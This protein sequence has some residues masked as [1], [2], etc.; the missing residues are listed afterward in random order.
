MA[1]SAPSSRSIAGM[2]KPSQK[3]GSGCAAIATPPWRWTVVDRV[4]GALHEADGCRN[5]GGDQ[6]IARPDDFLADEHDWPADHARKPLAQA[7]VPR[8]V[9]RGDGERVE[10]LALGFEDEPQGVSAPSLHIELCV[11]KSTARTR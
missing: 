2:S 11:W 4:G 3:S 9:V 8:F 1:D 5:A 10:A 7:R 6:V